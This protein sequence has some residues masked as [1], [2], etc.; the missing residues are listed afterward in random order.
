MQ[1]NDFQELGRRAGRRSVSMV[2]AAAVLTLMVGCVRPPS[3]SVFRVVD[4]Q[5]PGVIK[6]Y[7]ESFGVGWYKLDDHGNLDLILQRTG[8]SETGSEPSL[9]Q[10][11][12]VRSI[13]RSVPGQTIAHETQINGTIT[14]YL[15]SG[16]VGSAYDGAGSVFFWKKKDGTLF[17]TV[18]HALVRPTRRLGDDRPLFVQAELSGEFVALPDSRRVVEL[19]NRMNG[20]FGLPPSFQP[21]V[22]STH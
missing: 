12:H 16:R 9:E 17:G 15:L 14:Y 21:P 11:V 3:E 1:R 20:L 18:E 4:H 8:G 5:K 22:A 2:T 13:W 7:R 19:L 6:R 10:F